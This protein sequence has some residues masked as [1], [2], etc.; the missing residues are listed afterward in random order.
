MAERLADEIAIRGLIEQLSMA[1]GAGDARA[2]AAAFTPDADYITFMGTHHRGRADI[3][4]CHA[5]LFERFQKGSRLDGVVDQVRF[6]TSDVA[7]VHGR[8]AVVK[9]K[10][11]RNRR[12]TKVQ[13]WVVVRRNG[14]WEVAAFHNTEYHWLMVALTSKFDARTGSSARTG[15]E[16]GGLPA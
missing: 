6:L 16:V 2:Y 12:N 8:G 10:R 14:P 13:T 1:W 15:P 7:L 3:E 5:A 4:A 9:G 11:Q